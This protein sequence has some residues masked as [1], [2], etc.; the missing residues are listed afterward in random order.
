MSTSPA[1]DGTRAGDY[2]LVNCQ[3]ATPVCSCPGFTYHRDCPH[4]AIVAAQLDALCR[5]R[6]AR[7]AA[8]KAAREGRA[9]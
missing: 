3:G 8:E 9:A 4:V 7:W 1:A 5:A 2:Y 6:T